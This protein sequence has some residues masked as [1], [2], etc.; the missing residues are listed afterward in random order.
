VNG[1][2]QLKRE[3]NDPELES[4]EYLVI[5]EGEEIKILPRGSSAI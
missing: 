2:V 4:T 3:V 5:V 1:T